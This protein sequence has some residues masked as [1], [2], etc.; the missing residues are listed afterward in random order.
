MGL[1]NRKP[2]LTEDD[3]EDIQTIEDQCQHPE[4]DTDLTSSVYSDLLKRGVWQE[5][6][7][8]GEWVW[9]KQRKPV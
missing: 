8:T 3:L 6:L 4:H 5:Q 9:H 1:F 2:K 7:P